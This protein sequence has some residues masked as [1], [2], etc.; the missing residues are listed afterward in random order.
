VA[1]IREEGLLSFIIIFS[2]VAAIVFG[3]VII[4]NRLVRLRNRVRSSWADIDV[5]LRKRHNLVPRLVDTV[6]GYAKH[7]S[8]VFAKTAELRAN[9]IR[10]SGPSEIAQSEN[11]FVD[12]LRSFM[13]VAEAYPDLKASHG[14]LRLQGQFQELEDD[15]E[16]ARRYYNAVVRDYNSAI[17]VFPGVIV[18]SIC[19]FKAAEFFEIESP[20]E[21]I[22]SKPDFN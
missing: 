17:E 18:A 3:G 21:R 19:R 16:S 14:F 13:A 2:V 10:G 9:A 5:Q 22:A 20:Q 8:E 15:I 11:T 1:R 4:Y 6:K 7:E 12:A